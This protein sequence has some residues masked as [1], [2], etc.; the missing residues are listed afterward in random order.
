MRNLGIVCVTAAIVGLA[1]SQ[2][3]AAVTQVEQTFAQRAASGGMAELQ[4]AQLAQQRASSPQVKQFAGRMLADHGQANNE[5]QQIAQDQN[6][7]LPSAPDRTAVATQQKLHG[8]N[9]REFDQAYSQHEL[10][11][12]EQDVALFRQEATSGQNPALKSFA[13]KTLPILQQHLQLA[14]GLNAGR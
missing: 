2:A 8:L 1:A 12:H 10:R 7:T 5:L 13:Q 11:D 14:Q 3:S 9:G 4:A 6:I